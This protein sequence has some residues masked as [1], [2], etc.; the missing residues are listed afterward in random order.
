MLC[1]AVPAPAHVPAHPDVS[2]APLVQADP[3]D[4]Q[5][6]AAFLFRFG[7]YVE[8]PGGSPGADSSGPLVIGVF[9]D[10]AYL[11]ALR[12]VAGGAAVEGRAIEVRELNRPDDLEGLSMVFLGTDDPLE[13]S[14]ALRAAAR[15]S[16]LTV[17]YAE[18]FA[19]RG[20]MVNF[21]IEERKMRFEVNVGAAQDQ[22]IRLS[23]QLLR[24]AKI[25]STGD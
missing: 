6:V 9:A 19:E 14:Q 17:G 2:A 8:W 15:E 24:L 22:G 5:L 23:S 21:F 7:R 18:G 13:I 12:R 20:G 11:E 4:S 16:V 25:V 10:A 1:M 3:G